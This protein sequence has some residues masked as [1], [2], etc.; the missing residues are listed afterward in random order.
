MQNT[1]VVGGMAVG[2][3]IK[4]EILGENEKGERKKSVKIA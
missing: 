3:K 1:M 4:M 2:Q